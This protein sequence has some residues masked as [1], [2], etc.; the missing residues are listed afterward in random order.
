MTQKTQG[1]LSLEALLALGFFSI[2][3]SG[4]M[5]TLA[6]AMQISQSMQVVESL[7]NKSQQ[8]VY[9]LAQLNN[10]Q[11]SLNTTKTIVA[12]SACA[13]TY[14]A[15]STE[16]IYGRAVAMQETRSVI[17]IEELMRRGR[18]CPAAS[19]NKELRHEVI[20]LPQNMPQINTLDAIN[21]GDYQILAMG[22]L[23]EDTED[24][25]FIRLDGNKASLE[26][27][28]ESGKGI[29]DLDAFWI[30]DRA[31]VAGAHYSDKDQ[32]LVFDITNASKATEVGR[33]NLP[34]VGNSYP[35]GFSV[36]Y[37][38]ERIYVG[39]RE[40]AG[41]ELHA[42]DAS[43][44]RK[45]A[46]TNKREINHNIHDL[47]GFDGLL[48]AT[49]SADREDIMVFAP[50]LEKHSSIHFSD[51]N[52]A[53][54]AW[55]LDITKGSIALGRRESRQGQALAQEMVQIPENTKTFENN[56]DKPTQV[57]YI[58]SMEA[59]IMYVTSNGQLYL[60]D[61]VL[62]SSDK[63]FTAA[64]TLSDGRIVA[65]DELGNLHIWQ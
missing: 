21:Y 49:T 51:T 42:Y 9:E 56:S 41:N 38:D 11:S 15:V 16:N 17:D 32:L 44:L 19:V 14:K 22:T 35:Q 20:K 37:Y 18:D 54:D 61:E 36:T 40:T 12:N 60:N 33:Y 59:G 46:H 30:E 39:T 57:I 45:L 1:S 48:Y 62:Y 52:S 27:I 65:V 28:I 55:T 10:T 34:Q 13:P 3:C 2:V 23:N 63:K 53:V 7:S 64:E 6:S 24:L 8:G 43:N 50:N 47:A 5:L 29:K 31:Y 26:S 25:W 58:K 4:S